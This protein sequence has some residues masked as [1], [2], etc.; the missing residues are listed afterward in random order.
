ME[1]ETGEV[2][3]IS[4]LSKDSVEQYKEDYNYAIGRHMAP[5]STFKL[6]SIIAGLENNKFELSD[7]IDL[8]GEK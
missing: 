4:N 5:G 3:V 8:N 2:K 6:A 7:L 1:V